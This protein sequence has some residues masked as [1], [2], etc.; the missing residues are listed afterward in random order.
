[1]NTLDTILTQKARPLPVIVAIDR[2]GSMSIDGKIDALNRALSNFIDSVRKED[3]PKAEIQVALYSFGMDEATCD[4]PLAPISGIT[5]VPEYKAYGRT[6]MGMA[7]KQ[8]KELIEDRN[9]LPSRAY[10]P[11]I[12]LITDGQPTDE[13]SAFM[14]AM[15]S[16]IN[17]GRSAKAFRMAMA[18]GDDADRDMLSRF[19]SEPEY[20]VSGENARDIKKF[21]KYVTMSVTSRVKSQTPDQVPP[22]SYPTDNDILDF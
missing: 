22:P 11:T 12:V 15:D 9:L 2:S 7:F 21:F 10:R 5:D 14:E 19:V 16:L 3:S 20:L 1:M 8:M 17:E 18:I 13:P 4:L 6:P